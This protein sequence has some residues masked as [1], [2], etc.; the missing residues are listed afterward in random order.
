M[1]KSNI[2]IKFK[3]MS[4]K[5]NSTPIIERKPLPK[6]DIEKTKEKLSYIKLRAF[7]HIDRVFET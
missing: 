2:Y 4:E 7:S 5:I 6:L 3:N 1:L